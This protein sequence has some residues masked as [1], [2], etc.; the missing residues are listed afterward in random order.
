MCVSRIVRF[1]HKEG[2]SP[3]AVELAIDDLHSFFEKL[4]DLL[5]EDIKAIFGGEAG[6][7]QNGR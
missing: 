4:E 1:V 6:H 5:Q 3:E 7:A 2:N